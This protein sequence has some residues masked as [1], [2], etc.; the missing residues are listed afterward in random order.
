[1][2]TGNSRQVFYY[3]SAEYPEI[4]KFVADNQR[5]RSRIIRGLLGLYL[6]GLLIFD[7]ETYDTRN[8]DIE[9]ENLRPDERHIADRIK[10][11]TSLR[12]AVVVRPSK[13]ASQSEPPDD[14]SLGT[15]LTDLGIIIDKMG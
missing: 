9:S 11:P 8:Q 1:M 13:E 7:Q 14:D 5:G 10:S 3:I 2:A 6:R 4:A 15:G 12:P